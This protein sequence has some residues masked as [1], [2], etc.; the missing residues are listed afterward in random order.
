MRS[1]NTGIADDAALKKEWGNCPAIAVAGFPPVRD[2]QDSIDVIRV[3]PL[4]TGIRNIEEFIAACQGLYSFTVSV[5]R[6]IAY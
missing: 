3:I 2:G 6:E 1:L 4:Q 5:N